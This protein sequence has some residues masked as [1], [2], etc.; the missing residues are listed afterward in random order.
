MVEN[1]CNISFRQM[2]SLPRNTHRY[3]VEPVSGIPHIKS[4]LIKNFLNFIEQIKESKKTVPKVLLNTIKN[5]VNSVTGS[6]LRCI[7]QLVNV[8]NIDELNPKHSK[9][10]K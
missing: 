1:S 4:V 10:V 7:M 9:L 6:N 8:E 5:N 3:F 2:Y